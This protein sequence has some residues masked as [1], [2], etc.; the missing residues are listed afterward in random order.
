MK[1][2]LISERKPLSP[3]ARVQGEGWQAAMARRR[4]A[5]QRQRIAGA[6]TPPIRNGERELVSR[7]RGFRKN[8]FANIARA[9]IGVSQGTATSARARFDF[10][11]AFT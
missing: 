1:S 3:A 8:E 4:D 7:R 11:A 9:T 10:S 6:T 2:P 5:V